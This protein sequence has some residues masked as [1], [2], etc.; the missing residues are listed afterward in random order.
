MQLELLHDGAIVK[1]LPLHLAESSHVS[2]RS[3]N[4]DVVSRNS[5]QTA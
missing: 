2:E 4:S 5:H 3:R 1:V